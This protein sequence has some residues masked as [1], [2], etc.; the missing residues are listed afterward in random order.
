MRCALTV[1][2]SVS[3]LGTGGMK[4]SSFSADACRAG[5]GY[6]DYLPQAQ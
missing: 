6:R 3:G 4:A 1:G 5:I 2:D